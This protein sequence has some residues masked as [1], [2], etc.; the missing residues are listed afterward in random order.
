MP[1]GKDLIEKTSLVSIII[2]TRNRPQ[3]LRQCLKH[4]LVQKYK[5]FETI[6][7][8]ASS[9]QETKQVVRQYSEVK[10]I[11]LPDGQNQMT[12]SR[13]QGIAAATGEIIAFIDDDS[14]VQNDWLANLVASYCAEDIGGVGGRVIDENE[15]KNQLVLAAPVVGK[16]LPDGELIDNFALDLNENI[17]VDRL[18]G[19]NMS[20]RKTVFQHIGLFDNHYDYTAHS[21][22]EEVDFC[23]RV[24][25]SG[26]KLLFNPHATVIH[27]NAMREDGAPRNV[28]TTRMMFAYYHNRTYFVLTNFG[29]VGS[30]FIS[31]FCYDTVHHLY[32]FFKNPSKLNLLGLCSNIWGKLT[33]A[34]AAL[35]KKLVRK[36]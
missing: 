35:H 12:R 11:H 28:T 32:L 8:D 22:F 16:V 36:V 30:H 19:C 23:T 2:V 4:L 6:V 10:Y 18:R 3:M 21:T 20:F 1:S 7:V 15:K 33:G 13:N 9:D 34:A 14:M 27:L 26:Y 31:L 29:W 17:E 25:R 5:S 24:K